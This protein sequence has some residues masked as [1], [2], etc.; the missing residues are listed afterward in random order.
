MKPIRS[1]VH[2][3]IMLVLGCCA[4]AACDPDDACDPGFY[5]DHGYCYLSDGGP[6]PFSDTGL[7][8][9]SGELIQ[10]PNATHGM[11][12]VEQSDCGGVAP[13]CGGPMLPI[14]TS[15][16]CLTGGSGCPP[17][18]LCVDISKYEPAPGVTS[19]CVQP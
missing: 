2:A 10:N 8:A 5:A 4:A 7:D 9:D 14:C 11:S 1:R 17:G 15:I 18:W 16:N 6:S 13:A 19:V 3:V 12:C